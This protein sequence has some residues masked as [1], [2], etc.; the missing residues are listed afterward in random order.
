M[1]PRRGWEGPW[2]TRRGFGCTS[3]LENLGKDLSLPICK[4]ASLKNQMGLGVR[5]Q[6]EG[7]VVRVAVR[8][9]DLTLDRWLAAFPVTIVASFG[10]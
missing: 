4:S 1:P 6:R 10:F 2:K 5:A 9:M 7:I 3:A 8:G